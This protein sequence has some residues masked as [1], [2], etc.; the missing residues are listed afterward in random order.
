[1]KAPILHRTTL[2]TLYCPNYL[3][4]KKERKKEKKII[5]Q[6]RNKRKKKSRK[7]GSRNINSQSTSTEIFAGGFTRSPKHTVHEPDHEVPYREH[8]FPKDFWV[9]SLQEP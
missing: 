2:I 1:M 3:K 6:T 9:C 4:N 8:R 5:H 7:A